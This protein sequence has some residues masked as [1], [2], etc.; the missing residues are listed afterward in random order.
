MPAFRTREDHMNVD[1]A[2]IGGGLAGSTLGTVLARQGAKVLILERE[3]KFKDRV[4]GENMMPWGVERARRLGVLDDLLAAGGRLVPFFDTYAMGHRMEHRPMPK[5]TPCGEACLNMYHP[6]LQEALI[7]GAARAGCD[8][9]RGATVDAVSENGAGWTLTFTRDGRAETAS[10]RLVVG[11]DGRFSSMRQW[12]GFAVTRDPERFRIA[13]ALVTGTST[14]EDCTALLMG[15]GIAS[16]VAPLGGGRA[17]MYFIYVGAMGDRKLSGPEKIDEFAGGL[18][19]AGVPAAW[20]ERAEI[21]G[22]LAEFD[23]ADQSV[24]HPARPGL[25]NRSKLGLRSVEDDG[26]RGESRGK[27]RGDRRLGCGAARVR[28][29]TRR[30]LPQAARHHG[31]DDGASLDPGSG[32]R[33]AAR[34]R[35]PPHAGGSHGIP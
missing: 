20:L 8:V 13:G 25:G 2:I 30:S 34:A 4:R 11:A 27:A 32:G 35:L 9:R 23:G 16:F 18:R 17:R 6:D 3:T 7:A 5:T 10:A 31:L 22:P 26:G 21:V 19:A 28:A 33:R 29:R 14:P 24:A 15:P 1:V 12:G